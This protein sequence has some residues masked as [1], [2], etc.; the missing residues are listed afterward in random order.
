MQGFSFLRLDEKA[1]SHF[2]PEKSSKR[3]SPPHAAIPEL[4]S[5]TRSLSTWRG[6][7]RSSSSL[8]HYGM[9]APSKGRHDYY[10]PSPAPPLGE[11]KQSPR[12]FRGEA[13]EGLLMLR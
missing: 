13:G 7:N 5:P 2:S 12:P 10:F 11:G 1:F 3:A 6:C 8:L 9:L 4:R